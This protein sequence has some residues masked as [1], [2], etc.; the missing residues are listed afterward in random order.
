MGTSK[1]IHYTSKPGKT[2]YYNK[3]INLNTIIKKLKNKNYKIQFHKSCISK[4]TNSTTNEEKHI[5]S[6]QNYQFQR[7]N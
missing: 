2:E 7:K 1:T 3:I 5:A 6:Q 4:T